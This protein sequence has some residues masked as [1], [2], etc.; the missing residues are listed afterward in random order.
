MTQLRFEGGPPK[1][2]TDAVP[3]LRP[4]LREFFILDSRRECT[5]ERRELVRSKRVKSVTYLVPRTY[6]HKLR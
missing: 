6:L 4:K 5:E 1:Q 2:K 3:K